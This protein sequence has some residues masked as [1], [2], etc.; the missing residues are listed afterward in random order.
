MD[1]TPQASGVQS[2]NAVPIVYAKSA[3]TGGLD[4]SAAL[5]ALADAGLP[6]EA[7]A[8]AVAA[9]MRAAR[10]APTAAPRLVEGA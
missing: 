10:P 7:L 5:R 8:A 6:P 3:E 4:L 9:L 2:P 1:A